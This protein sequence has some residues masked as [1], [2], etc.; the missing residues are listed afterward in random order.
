MIVYEALAFFAGILFWECRRRLRTLVRSVFPVLPVLPAPSPL[1]LLRALPF[2]RYPLRSETLSS[3][4]FSIP[5]TP[6]NVSQPCSSSLFQS[7]ILL[8]FSPPIL[9]LVSLFTS[10]PRPCFHFLFR[11]ATLFLFPFPIRDLLPFSPPIRDLVSLF[12]SVPRP[13]FPF[14]FRSAT[15][16]PYLIRPVTLFPFLSY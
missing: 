14:L 15:L 11:S 9:D 10:V 6:S 8:P 13:C 12:S 3:I 2:D 1:S 7:A 4:C 5:L 16:F